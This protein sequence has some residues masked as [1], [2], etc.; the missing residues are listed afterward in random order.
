MIL[1]H[2]DPFYRTKTDEERAKNP[3]SIQSIRLNKREVTIV[4]SVG[5]LIEEDKTSSIIK[6]LMLFGADALHN[7][8]LG[9]YTE[10]LFKKRKQ[11][12]RLGILIQD[13]E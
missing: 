3:H 13:D 2:D 5:K 12:R 4:Q 8:L 11:N 1:K 7:S 10:K 9:T 6:W